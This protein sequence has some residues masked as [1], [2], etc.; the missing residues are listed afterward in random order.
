MKGKKK[1]R[2]PSCLSLELLELLEPTFMF[3]T[4][5]ETI[6]NQDYFAQRLWCAVKEEP[7][8]RSGPVALVH[9]KDTAG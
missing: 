1:Q 9:R 5:D 6:E 2:V 8:E 7:P 4:K 3:N